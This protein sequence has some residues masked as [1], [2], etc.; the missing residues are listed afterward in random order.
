MSSQSKVTIG[1]TCK[2]DSLNHTLQQNVQH[3]IKKALDPY[4]NEVDA[5]DTQPQ[6]KDRQKIEERELE[7]LLLI[8]VLELKTLTFTLTLTLTLVIIIIMMLRN[9]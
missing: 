8:K 4:H 1:H 6:K 9:W 5:D 7:H 2:R 3:K